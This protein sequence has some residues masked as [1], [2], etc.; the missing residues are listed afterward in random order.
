[1]LLCGVGMG[2]MGTRGHARTRGAHPGFVA[3][4]FPC[5]AAG[6][7]RKELVWGLEEA[8]SS[9]GGCRCRHGAGFWGAQPRS[10]CL[11]EQ[12][13]ERQV[14]QTQCR[15]L[16]AQHYSLSL[17]AEQLSHSM[18][19]SGGH[20]KSGGGAPSS[21]G[22]PIFLQDPIPFWCPH[23]PAVPHPPLVSPSSCHAPVPFWCP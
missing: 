14:L 10:P 23:I 19:V 22:A 5:P 12:N 9:P 6:L 15:R 11:A 3:S 13:L 21:C 1:M 18:A 17:T 8:V 2:V 7:G 16:E 20:P 4:S